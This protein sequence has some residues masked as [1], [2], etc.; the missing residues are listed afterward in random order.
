MNSGGPAGQRLL[1][2]RGITKVFPGV[3]ALSGVSLSIPEGSVTALVGENGA[4]KST[5]IKILGGNY[6]P[7]AG[8][9]LLDGR[10][11]TIP[12]PAAA[13]A[14]G[15]SVIHQEL[16]LVPDLSV[17]EN[18]FLHH[19]PANRFG[20]LDRRR[21]AS[22]ARDVLARLGCDFD[23]RQPVRQ[24]TLAQKQL[25]EIARALTLRSRL[26]VMDEPTAALNE[27]ETERLFAIIDDFRARQTAV[28]YISHRLEEVLR[29]ADFI[30]VLR[31][32]ENAGRLTRAEATPEEVIRLMVGREVSERFP[33][34]PASPGDPLLTAEGL[35]SPGVLKD[36]SFTLHRGEILGIGGLMGAG[37]YL[38]ARCLFGLLPLS[39]GHLSV[40][41]RRLHPL[42]PGTAIRAGLALLPENRKEDG[43]VLPASVRANLELASLPCL[44]GCLGWL[45]RRKEADLV[46]TEFH[47]LAI[48]ASGPGQ[49]VKDLSGGNQ[50]KVVLGKWLATDAQIIVMC[51]PTRGIDV[52]TKAEI[53]R[54]MGNLTAA[55]KGII[56]ISSELPELLAL[57]DRVLVMNEGRVAGI[58]PRAEASPEQVM[59][60]ATGGVTHAHA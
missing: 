29:L 48:K 11:V 25:V 31:D 16:T 44:S 2:M 4:G 58:L 23:P 34:R 18:I 38:L 51:E 21:L 57:S 42:S 54:L 47:R 12:S 55:G 22:G 1:E 40:R 39:S 59:R 43:L 9:I 19:F 53:Y 27:T 37:Q 8:E 56:L 30:F 5:L 52:G 13:R 41:G 3:R 36:V 33:K 32:G 17:A 46:A 24:L 10:P 7:D 6:P 49:P 15:I 26:I 35:S 28:V 50:Q 45:N 14:L 60:L 20:W